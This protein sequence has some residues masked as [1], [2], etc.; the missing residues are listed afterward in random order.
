MKTIRVTCIRTKM[1]GGGTSYSVYVQTRYKAYYPKSGFTYATTYH[2]DGRKYYSVSDFLRTS[3]VDSL[4]PM[5]DE[6]CH[7]FRR[8]E[9]LS[10]RIAFLACVKAFPEIRK[11]GKIPLLWTNET[12]DSS[13]VDIRFKLNAKNV[14]RLSVV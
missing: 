12:H 2:E 3:D 7:A 10:A 13:R 4:P 1:I 6:R 9:R 14:E 8:I 11:Y 5:T